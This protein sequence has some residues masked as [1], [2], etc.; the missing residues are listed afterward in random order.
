MTILISLRTRQACAEHRLDSV[1]IRSRP[2]F[3]VS[4]VLASG[5]YPGEY[6]KGKRIEIGEVSSGKYHRTKTAFHLLVW[7]EVVVFH[8]G[9]SLSGDE[10][11][12]TGGRVLAVSAAAPSLEEALSSVYTAIDEISFEGKVY[13]RDIAHRRAIFRSSEWSTLLICKL[14]Y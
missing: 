12:T 3:A 10:L 2:G 8:C 1:Q 5:G 11:V 13:R 6:S 4:V 9:T 14:E 7:T